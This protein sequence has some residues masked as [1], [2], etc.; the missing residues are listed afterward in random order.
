MN[1]SVGESHCG[2]VLDL[3]RD[4]AKVLANKDESKNTFHGILFFA[5]NRPLIATIFSS[6]KKIHT[7]SRGR[8][9]GGCRCGERRKDSN[10]HHGVDL[11]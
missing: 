5:S 6:S 2:I 7:G 11:N 8:G 10:L 3:F 9:K 1:K 4:D